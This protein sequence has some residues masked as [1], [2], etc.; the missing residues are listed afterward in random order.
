MDNEI[1]EENEGNG[2]ENAAPDPEPAEV[3]DD[4]DVEPAIE[5]VEGFFLI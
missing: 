5:I 1:N 2:E 3:A 4:P